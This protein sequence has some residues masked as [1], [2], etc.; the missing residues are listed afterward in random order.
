MRLFRTVLTLGV[1]AVS[2][3]AQDGKEKHAYQVSTCP[4]FRC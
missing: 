4:R 1:F 2:A 3:L